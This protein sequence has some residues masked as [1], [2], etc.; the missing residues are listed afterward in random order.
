MF[1]C[2]SL[3]GSA[4]FLPLINVIPAHLDKFHVLCASL[5][6]SAFFLPGGITGIINM[7]GG[8]K[9]IEVDVINELLSKSHRNLNLFQIKLNL[10]NNSHSYLIVMLSLSVS[11]F[12]A[13]P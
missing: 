1:L 3:I 7:N 13:L 4:F 5:I 2:A 11:C 9:S 6:G 8:F 10:S 12:Y